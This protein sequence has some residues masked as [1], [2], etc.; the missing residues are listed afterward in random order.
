M[1][2]QPPGALAA[3]FLAAIKPVIERGVSADQI[4]ELIAVM[5]DWQE[6]I[7]RLTRERD[8][9]RQERDYLLDTLAD[10]GGIHVVKNER[11]CDCVSWTCAERFETRQDY[12]EYC[13]IVER[14]AEGP[15]SISIV[16]ARELEHFEAEDRDHVMEAFEDGRGT[17][18]IL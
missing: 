10:Q 15:V 13:E 5:G 14:N 16:A 18:V 17:A 2:P 3:Q 6:R 11:D 7:P 12:N 8:A 9:A 1:P 4:A